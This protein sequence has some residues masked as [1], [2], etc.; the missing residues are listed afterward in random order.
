ML[1]V[2]DPHNL[3]ISSFSVWS[4]SIF[5]GCILVFLHINCSSL[6]QFHSLMP[7]ILCKGFRILM[8]ALLLIPNSKWRY[9]TTRNI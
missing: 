7:I 4:S 1:C 9:V 8:L 2:I 5:K 6:V 3:G